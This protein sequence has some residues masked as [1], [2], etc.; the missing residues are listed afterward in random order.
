MR[1]FAIC[2]FG[3]AKASHVAGGQWVQ[4][5]EIGKHGALDMCVCIY[6]LNAKYS[7]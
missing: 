4:V 3:S 7:S 5:N 1:Q 2:I 6:Y